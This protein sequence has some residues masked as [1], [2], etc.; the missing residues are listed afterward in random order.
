MVWNKI[1]LL[2]A[3]LV[4]NGCIYSTEL[5]CEGFKDAGRGCKPVTSN[6]E[7]AVLMEQQKEISKADNAPEKKDKVDD[8]ISYSIKLDEAS[9]VTSMPKTMKVVI[10]P[11][12]DETGRLHM[13]KRVYI[14]IQKPE[15][16]IGDYLIPETKKAEQ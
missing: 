5:G 2:S 13:L 4:L 8:L 6:V 14:I 11:R 1:T 3:L 15:W 7:Y 9:P 16:I 12:V 10:M